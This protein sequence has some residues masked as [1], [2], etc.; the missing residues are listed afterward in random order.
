MV[1]FDLQI[2][3]SIM[4]EIVC[5]VAKKGIM[6]NRQLGIVTF[7]SSLVHNF[8][9]GKNPTTKSNKSKLDC[10]TLFRI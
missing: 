1:C 3:L 8:H 6:L 4:S 5:F 7:K 9:K 10:T 2:S